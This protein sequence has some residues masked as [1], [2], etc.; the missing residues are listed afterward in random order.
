MRRG[1]AGLQKRATCSGQMIETFQVQKPWCNQP[2]TM[3]AMQS[4]PWMDA[5]MPERLSQVMLG[6]ASQISSGTP[7][8]LLA[9]MANHA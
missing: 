9:V 2:T 1:R 4:L 6:H 7:Y 3:M 8:T 5:G